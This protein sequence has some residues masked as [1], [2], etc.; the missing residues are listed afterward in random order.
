MSKNE[1]SIDEMIDLFEE[2]TEL[3]HDQK[4]YEMEKDQP[5]N[6]SWVHIWCSTGGTATDTCVGITYDN[7]VDFQQQFLRTVRLFFNPETLKRITE[8][9]I[10]NFGI[11]IG[12]EQPS[13]GNINEELGLEVSYDTE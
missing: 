11:Q 6:F 9:S 10:K 4:H 3:M 8:G 7:T 1:T 12:P 5:S 13:G 2:A